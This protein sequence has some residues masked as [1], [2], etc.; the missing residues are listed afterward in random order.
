MSFSVRFIFIGCLQ[1]SPCMNG[2]YIAGITKTRFRI[3]AIIRVSLI[4]K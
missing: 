4:H 3:F 2:I 1:I